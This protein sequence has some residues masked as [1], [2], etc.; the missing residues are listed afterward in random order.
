MPTPCTFHQDTPGLA[1]VGCKRE[2]DHAPFLGTLGVQHLAATPPRGR[3]H[4]NTSHAVQG[5]WGKHPFYVVSASADLIHTH[6]YMVMMVHTCR[7]HE[8]V[9]EKAQL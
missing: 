5:L 6:V 4:G 9:C 8:S 1:W 7:A 3:V 2:L